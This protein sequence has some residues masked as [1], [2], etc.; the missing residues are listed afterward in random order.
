M[1]AIL[2]KLTNYVQSQ[3]HRIYPENWEGDGWLPVPP[4]FEAVAVAN[5]PY[6]EV[7]YS[8]DGENI[9]GITPIERPPEPEPEPTQDPIAKL[10]QENALLKQQAQALT[11]QM[12]F[13]EEIFVELAN[14]IYA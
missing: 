8:A 1:S 4:E 11:E 2:Q 9:A 5:A 13:H 12:A 6:I 10:E 7:K 14:V 3:S